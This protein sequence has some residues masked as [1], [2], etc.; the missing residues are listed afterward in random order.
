[1]KIHFKIESQ[2]TSFWKCQ[3]EILSLLK[4]ISLSLNLTYFLAKITH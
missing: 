2:N 4:E 3:N 1:M